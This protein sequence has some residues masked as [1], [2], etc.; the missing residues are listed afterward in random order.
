VAIEQIED[1]TPSHRPPSTPSH[2]DPIRSSGGTPTF[3][4]KRPVDVKKRGLRSSYREGL[5]HRILVSHANLM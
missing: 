3:S 5:H 1:K 4:N 2:N